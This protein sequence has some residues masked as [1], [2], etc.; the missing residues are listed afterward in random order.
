ML[1]T[2]KWFR[3]IGNRF[4]E[5]FS[6]VSEEKDQVV[7]QGKGANEAHQYE[8]TKKIAFSKCNSI[9][10]YLIWFYRTILIVQA[11]PQLIKIINTLCGTFKQ[12]IMLENLSL[13]IMEHNNR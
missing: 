13:K 1:Y 10:Y 8:K 5:V 7:W 12:L 11:P 6:M 3:G 4:S 2:Y 9:I